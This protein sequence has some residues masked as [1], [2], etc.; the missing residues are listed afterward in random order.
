MVAETEGKKLYSYCP[1][2]NAVS[3][4]YSK[5]HA[6]FLSSSHQ[7]FLQAF[8]LIVCLMVGLVLWHINHC[9]VINAKSILIHKQIYLKQF[10]LAYKNSYILSKLV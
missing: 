3:G 4:I 1:L 10:S 2:W 7:V 5:Q 8:R 6:V 9:E